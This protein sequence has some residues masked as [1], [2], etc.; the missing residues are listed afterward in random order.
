MRTPSPAAGGLAASSSPR[1]ASGQETNN[2]GSPD[3]RPRSPV[4]TAAQILRLVTHVGRGASRTQRVVGRGGIREALY[5][6]Y[7]GQRSQRRGL[8]VGHV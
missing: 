6:V 3:V 4:F 2:V 5:W 1:P 8:I 7:V